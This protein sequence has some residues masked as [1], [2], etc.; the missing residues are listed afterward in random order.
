MDFAYEMYLSYDT[1]LSHGSLPRFS[2]SG[3]GALFVSCFV[4]INDITATCY[5]HSACYQNDI[6]I[7]LEERAHALTTASFRCDDQGTHACVTVNKQRIDK[8]LRN[9]ICIHG[10]L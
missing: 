4:L 10:L 2:S 1:N 6:L 3:P 7:L 5:D 8:S 9:R